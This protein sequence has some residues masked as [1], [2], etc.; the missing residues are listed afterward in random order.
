[1]GKVQVI[2]VGVT[3]SGGHDNVVVGI[4]PRVTTNWPEPV[5]SWPRIVIVFDASSTDT[6]V[7]CNAAMATGRSTTRATARARVVTSARV[8]RGHLLAGPRRCP[9]GGRRRALRLS[10]S[11]LVLSH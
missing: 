11:K 8:R 9:D 6:A 1:M 2:D 10:V 7:I 4:V 5:N 3:V